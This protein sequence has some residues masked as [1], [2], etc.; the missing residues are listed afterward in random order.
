MDELKPIAFATYYRKNNKLYKYNY[1]DL[2]ISNFRQSYE[3]N[4]N[5]L[6][7]GA[8]TYIRNFDWKHNYDKVDSNKFGK[9]LPHDELNWFVNKDSYKPYDMKWLKLYFV[10]ISDTS[11]TSKIARD[12]FKCLKDNILKKPLIISIS[13]IDLFEKRL[14]GILKKQTR[15]SS[16]RKVGSTSCSIKKIGKQLKIVG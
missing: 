12:I 5:W 8:D 2:D 3:Q 7:M 15:K 9:I 16:S 13:T 10:D 1:K 6:T 11:N 14:G 4:Y